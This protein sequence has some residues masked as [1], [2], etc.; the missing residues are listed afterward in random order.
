[1]VRELEGL[2]AADKAQLAEKLHEASD[3]NHQAVQAEALTI[4]QAQNAQITQITQAIETEKEKLRANLAERE[5]LRV[6]LAQNALARAN[7]PSDEQLQAER[8]EIDKVLAHLAAAE[9]LHISISQMQN[10]FQRTN[11]DANAALKRYQADL[12]PI[13]IDD[14]EW[15]RLLQASYG[16][17]R[18]FPMA[19]WDEYETDEPSA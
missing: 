7:L 16:A 13:S 18:D 9:R 3:Q 2:S 4:N 14:D 8:A 12:N 15:L 5:R 6:E 10:D 19:D 1:M 11:D 17:L